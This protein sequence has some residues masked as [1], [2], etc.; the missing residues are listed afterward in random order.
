M[1]LECGQLA[2]SPQP[3]GPNGPWLV[4]VSGMPATGKTTL[5]RRL[6]ADVGVPFFAKDELK[7]TLFD[8]LGVGDRSWSRRLGAASMTLLRAIA[9]ATVSAGRSAV[10]EANFTLAYDAPFY[11]ELMARAGVRV[12]QV[13]LTAS[14][15]AIIERFERRAASPQRHPGHVELANMD[16]FR[17][18]LAREDDAPL[19]L[20]GPIR[21]VD[22]N[23]FATLDYP[24]LLEWLRAA[25]AGADAPGETS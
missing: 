1:P 5:G 3:A 8:T 7:E 14:P 15:D 21:R 9:E 10:I 22:T 23:D 19:P 12:A 24:A 2:R 6:A 17:R 25:L 11:Q 16:E 20:G 18:A 4:M 13:W